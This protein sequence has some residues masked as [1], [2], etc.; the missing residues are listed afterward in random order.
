[1]RTALSLLFMILLAG[2]VMPTMAQVETYQSTNNMDQSSSDSRSISRAYNAAGEASGLLRRIMSRENATR[3]IPDIMWQKAEAIAVFPTNQKFQ[4]LIGKDIIGVVS[5]RDPESRTWSAPIFLRIESDH[6]DD[7]H[8]EMNANLILI[9]TSQNMNN[10]FF[11]EKLE[12]GKDIAVLGGP[13]GAAESS[14]LDTLSPGMYAYIYSEGIRSRDS[15]TWN[16]SPIQ[17]VKIRHAFD[18]NQAIYG[19]NRLV[20]FQPVSRLIPTRVLVFPEL[21]NQITNDPAAF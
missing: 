6:W 2:T 4:P 7:E 16:G 10:A 9:S 18:I 19:T 21:L 20:R 14:N 17:N 1:M 12:L 5:M 11:K 3:N 8:G 13:F 15:H